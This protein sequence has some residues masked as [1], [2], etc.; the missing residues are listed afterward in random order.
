MRLGSIAALIGAEVGETEG[1]IEIRRVAKIEE[2]AAGD[3]TF[4]ANPKYLKYLTSTAASAVIVGRDVAPPAT[5]QA[6]VFLPVADPYSAFLRVLATLEPSP[7]PVPAGIHPSAVVDASAVLGADVRLGALVVVGP[8]CRLGDRAALG[9]GVVLGEDV[10]VGPDCIL[11]HRV[12]VRERCRI[13]AR[14]IIQ[15][16][17]VIGSDGFGFAPRADGSYEKIPQTGIVVIEDDVEIGA[18]TTIDR[19]TMGETIIRRGAKLD[20]LVQIAHNVV[21]GE[22]TVIA[23]QT[24]VSGS[25]R[26]GRNCV[27]A[28]QV[29]FVGHIEIADRTT[30]AAQSGVHKSVS[31]PGETLFGYPAHPHRQALRMQGAL[32]QLPELLG[33]VRD[34]QQKVAVLEERLSR[35]SL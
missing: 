27:I 31:R 20:N 18:N 32:T 1:E 10:E 29:G 5:A 33:T 30:I 4:V 21:V 28:G 6:P 3:I 14:V 19:A 11:H 23:A 16:G 34:L 9:H 24:G 7:D 12:T 35:R 2:A 26:L 8:G 22:H 15:P 25:T 17:A 13:G